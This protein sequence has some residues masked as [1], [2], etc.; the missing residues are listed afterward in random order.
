MT[1]R[2]EGGK[3]ESKGRGKDESKGRGKDESKGCGKDELRSP[4]E[5]TEANRREAQ[6]SQFGP[7]LA[8]RG[9]E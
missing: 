6:P 8:T 2:G 5:R 7:S 4:E 1:N 3:D 9:Q